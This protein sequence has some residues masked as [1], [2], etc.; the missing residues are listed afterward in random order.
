MSLKIKTLVGVDMEGTYRSSIEL[1]KRLDF[2]NQEWILA[3][4]IPTLPWYM[5][6][7]NPQMLNVSATVQSFEKASDAILEEASHS[8]TGSEFTKVKEDGDVAGALIRLADKNKVD[9]IVLGTGKPKHGLLWM[10]GSVSRALSIGAH[11]S[12]L[13]TKNELHEAGPIHAVFATDHSEFAN[14]AVDKLIAWAPKGI[15]RIDVVT[16]YEVNPA[17]LVM[18]KRDTDLNLDFEEWVRDHANAKSIEVAN[19]LKAIAPEVTV[20]VTKGEPNDVISKAMK[21]SG[22][23]LLILGAQ[24][25]GFLDRL[26]IGSISHHQMVAEPYP[27]L[28][29]RIA[30]PK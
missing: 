5:P 7:L 17:T 24:G 23:D 13:V 3:N 26:V 6:G 14:Q 11:Q 19:R 2:N 27:V 4:A 8:L 12:L 9:L 29:M 21:W 10:I 16:A 15:S 28:L 30:E 18:L 20:A 22:A 25:H 1:C